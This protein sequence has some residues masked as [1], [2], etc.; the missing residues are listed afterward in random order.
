[1]LSNQGVLNKFNTYI[2]GYLEV[3]QNLMDVRFIIH[4][5]NYLCTEFHHTYY[6]STRSIGLPKFSL[7][8]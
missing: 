3:L 7:Q 6:N 5:H 2:Y 4:I 1:M 8:Q